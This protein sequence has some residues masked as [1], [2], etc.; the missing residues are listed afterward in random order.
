MAARSELLKCMGLLKIVSVRP[1]ASAVTVTLK[2]APATTVEGALISSFAVVELQ[3]NAINPGVAGISAHSR[4]T[5]SALPNLKL[6][7]SR[8]GL[9]HK[10]VSVPHTRSSGV[11]VAA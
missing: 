9:I 1:A 10:P 6:A 11:A 5:A 4:R 2:G 7:D 8:A 3:A